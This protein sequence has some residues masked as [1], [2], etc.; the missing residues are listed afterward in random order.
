MQL[1]ENKTD[2]KKIVNMAIGQIGY[3]VPW[4]MWVDQDGTCYVN[5]QY[6][7]TNSP[8]GTSSLKVTRVE[9][10][11][12]VHIHESNHKWSRC[13]GNPFNTSDECV[14]GEVVGFEVESTR[15]VEAPKNA[16]DFRSIIGSL[17]FN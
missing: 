4:G 10:G 11:Y 12:V 15:K 14:Y 1:P 3:M 5:E 9:S 6:S 17:C 7:F 2:K 8:F 13:N 16:V